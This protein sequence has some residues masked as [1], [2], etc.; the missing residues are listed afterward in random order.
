MVQHLNWDPATISRIACKHLDQEGALLPVLHS[1]QTEFG[2]IPPDC[3]GQIA[4][5]FN[6][7]VDELFEYNSQIFEIVVNM[8]NLSFS[9]HT[10]YVHQASGVKQ[11]GIF[12]S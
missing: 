10:Q 3:V 9:S 8:E 4:D 6:V 7:S 5:L 1:I 12:L 2:H 11:L